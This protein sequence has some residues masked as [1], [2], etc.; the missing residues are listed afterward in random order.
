MCPS[1]TSRWPTQ[2]SP[3]HRESAGHTFVFGLSD[4]PV[5]DGSRGRNSARFLN[6]ACPPNCEA[7]ESGD[8]VFIHALADIVPG[9]ELFIYYALA[10]EGEPTDEIRK[11]YACLCGST[12]CRRTKLSAIDD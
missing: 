5:I 4:G 7:I 3:F 2:G 10:I 9:S 12:G 6:H 1:R 11:Q 8:R